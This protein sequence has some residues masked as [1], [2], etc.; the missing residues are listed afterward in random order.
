MHGYKGEEFRC[1]DRAKSETLPLELSLREV[2]H[3]TRE[4]GRRIFD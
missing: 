3:F 1:S 2:S 4:A